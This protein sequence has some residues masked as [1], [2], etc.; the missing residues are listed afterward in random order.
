MVAVLCVAVV[1]YTWWSRR[2]TVLARLP[3]SCVSVS[4]ALSA[5]LRP[6]APSSGAAGTPS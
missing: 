4:A 5:A 6:H 1:L 3:R 2:S